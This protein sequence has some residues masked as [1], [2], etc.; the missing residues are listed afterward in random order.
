MRN[1]IP[2]L[3]DKYRDYDLMQLRSALID[4]VNAFV[5]YKTIKYRKRQIVE[6]IDDSNVYDEYSLEID[7]LLKL[8]RKKMNEMV[9]D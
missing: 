9:G 3:M 6:G 4:N 8:I 5:D 1:T 7:V 2:K